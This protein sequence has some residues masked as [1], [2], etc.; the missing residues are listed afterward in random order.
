MEH[1]D[2]RVITIGSKDKKKANLNK[3]IVKKNI[4]NSNNIYNVNATKLENSD[5]IQL[6]YVDRNVVKKIIQART[7]QKISQQDLAN[8]LNVRKSVITEL[9]SGKMLKNNQFVSKVKKILRIIN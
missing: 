6:K 8:K 2:F 1:Q 9:E 5:E 4:S 3:Q 7:L